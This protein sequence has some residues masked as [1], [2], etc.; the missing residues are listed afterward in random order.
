MPKSMARSPRG[1]S[2]VGGPPWRDSTP[3]SARERGPS[4]EQSAGARRDPIWTS[5]PRAG[6]RTQKRTGSRP[7]SMKN[8]VGAGDCPGDAGA[9]IDG[10]LVSGGAGGVP[11]TYPSAGWHWQSLPVACPSGQRWARHRSVTRTSP[12]PANPPPLQPPVL[13]AAA[14]PSP[15]ETSPQYAG[16]RLG[17][18]APA[19]WQPPG[20]GSE[21]PAL[22]GVGCEAMS[23]LRMSVRLSGSPRAA[24]MSPRSSSVQ[25]CTSLI[26][27]PTAVQLL[28]HS[29]G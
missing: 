26:T 20:A 13:P 24:A 22:S 1:P 21:L 8:L 7:R 5:P 18:T 2:R 3:G 29:S 28:S 23:T 19:G 14:Y 10:P 15:Q 25:A 11:G 6:A 17:A 9:P 16:W 4:E 12:A 27:S